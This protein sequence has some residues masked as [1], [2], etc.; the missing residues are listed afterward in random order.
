MIINYYINDF[1]HNI[2]IS[3]KIEKNV[4]R[5][6]EKVNSDKKVLFVYDENIDSKIIFKIRDQLKIFGS[7]L[8]LIKIH[9]NKANKNIKILLKIIDVL[10]SSQFT[11]NSILI[12]CGGG[13]VGDLCNLAASVYLRGIIY[14]HIP[15][16]MTAIVDSCI[17][18]K[19]AINYRNIINSFGTYY[20]PKSVFIFKQIIDLLPEREFFAGIPEIIK[21]G[22]IKNSKILH[23]LKK[24]H[25]IIKKRNFYVLKKI[26][27][28]T[29]KTKIYFF[30]N[31]VFEKKNRLK[32]NF[33]HTFGHAIE[34]A[35]D[36]FIAKDYFRHGEAVGIGL[37]CEIYY[38]NGRNSKLLDY[39]KN[40]L[41]LY[42]L[43][44]SIKKENYKFDLIKIQN[45]IYKGIFLDKKKINNFPRYIYLKNKF[46]PQVKEIKNFNLLNLTI[47]NFLT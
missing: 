1:K 23:I 13:V 2:I 42:N 36:K 41:S 34:M 14:F 16:T 11:K 45:E 30:K 32:L 28:E 5:E 8:I 22:L 29:L 46:K 12:S 24:D 33:G 27:S 3:D 19:T 9:G 44:I 18:G 7:D 10:I 43:P 38:S 20:H 31:D 4:S 21:S 26:I 17:G 47:K 39:V 25:I 35:T 15:T 6:V 40:I 37:L